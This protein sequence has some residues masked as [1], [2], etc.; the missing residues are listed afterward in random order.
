MKHITRIFCMGKTGVDCIAG[1]LE[2]KVP[3]YSNGAY[4]IKCRWWKVTKVGKNANGEKLADL[5]PTDKPL[6]AYFFPDPDALINKQD[7]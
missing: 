1:H 7:A 6:L 3:M 2:T 5:V 4:K